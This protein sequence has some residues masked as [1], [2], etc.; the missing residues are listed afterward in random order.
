VI[1]LALRQRIGSRGGRT[2]C[3]TAPGVGCAPHSGS[4]RA[5]GGV[6]P[7]G[8]VVAEGIEDADGE[9]RRHPPS[10]LVRGEPADLRDR[11]HRRPGPGGRGWSCSPTP[12]RREAC[13]W[14]RRRRGSS[15]CFVDSHGPWVFPSTRGTFR[16][17]DNT[18]KQLREVLAGSAWE[19]Q[20]P[21]RAPARRCHTARRGR[22]ERPRDRRLPRPRADLDD[23]GRVHVPQGDRCPTQRLR[24]TFGP[25]SAG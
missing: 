3:V 13:A 17:P 11:G 18:R 16:D 25:Q 1:R 14:S 7:A 10:D 2:C 24:S 22:S 19:G 4:G 15:R 6:P 5:T 12:S 21:A 8:D 9:C 20:R 23:A